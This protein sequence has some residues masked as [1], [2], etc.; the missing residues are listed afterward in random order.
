MILSI[1]IC[2]LNEGILAVPQ[3]L[4][5]E[6]K[7]VNYV[8]SFQYTDSKFLLQIPELLY[9]RKDVSVC[10]L[11]GKG[12]SVNRNNALANATGDIALIADDDVR[13]KDEYLD[14]ILDTFRNHSDVDVALFR[15]KTYEGEW[16]KQYPNYSYNYKNAPKGT[17]PCSWEMTMRKEVYD[18]EVRFD[19][20]F[21][22][23][24]DFL[25]CGEEDVFM[26]DALAKGLNIVY[27]PKAIVETDC[28]TTGLKFLINKRVQRSKGAVF[29][30]CFGF[31]NALFCCVKEALYHAIYSH[32]NPFI[33]F[34]NMYDGIKYCRRTN[35]ER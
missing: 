7:D 14:T 35:S 27:F 32:A 11:Q 2:T 5:A 34:K 3:I 29:F 16:L 8:I 31:W 28:N 10:I 24:A 15:A 6:R 23:G 20:R 33:L 17:Y 9:Q 26:K 4:L 12:L 30:Y 18:Q 19:K 1:L 22:L 13:Y 25:S 21:G